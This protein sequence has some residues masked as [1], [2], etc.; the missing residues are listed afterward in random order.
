MKIIKKTAAALTAAV[1]LAAQAAYA[2]EIDV[3]IDSF[4]VTASLRSDTGTERPT[5]QLL[6]SAKSTVLYMG[7]GTSTQNDDDTYTFSFEPFNVPSSLETGQYVIRI[8]GNG[9]AI[10]EQTISFV[11]VNDKGEALNAINSAS[12][13]VAAIIENKDR[14]GI[15][16]LSLEALSDEWKGTISTAVA[17]ADLSNDCSE[18]QVAEKSA[19]FLEAYMPALE[20][21]V[22][23]GSDS[24]DEVNAM[25]EAS[26]YLGL[27]RDG[28]Y[29]KLSDKSSVGGV[30]AEK[31]F[32]TDI[33][34]EELNDE[35]DGAVLVCVINQLDH[36]SAREAL[37]E[38][39]SAG[40]LDVDMSDFDGLSET[41]KANVFKELKKRG[42]TD[43]EDIPGEFEDIVDSYKGSGG[44]STGGGNYGGGGGGGTGGGSTV[45]I[46][47]SPNLPAS[48]PAP[49]S[50][51][52][53]QG[54][55]DMEGFEWAE[56]AVN[57]LSG[58]GVLNGD[59]SGRF[60]PQ[61]YITREEF[62]KI[63]VTAF[64][65]YD[66]SAEAEFDDVPQEAWF[67]SYVASAKNNGIVTGISENEFGAGQNIT[68][69]DMAVML[70]RI[71][72]MAKYDGIT[73]NTDFSDYSE[74][75]DYAQEAVSILSGAGILNGM[76]GG[77]FAPNER[78]TRAQGAKAVYELLKLIEQ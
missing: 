29:S 26:E 45:T 55:T 19:I 52:E 4:T 10:E 1:M 41:N 70:K 42:I 32:G 17:A 57:E 14:L 34:A 43:Y 12:D 44:G 21:A 49:T 76:D 31:E 30:L 13:K 23:A 7:E 36:G 3:K 2:Y 47:G 6:D 61:N 46:P 8:G 37:E 66:S 77:R 60:N 71:F 53:P 63:T 38:Y 72:D 78:V 75:A 65:L 5:I 15:D 54:F 74:I 50:T 22:I 33:T 51:P 67:Y 18:E 39:T 73:P 56:E 68:R 9:T 59:G 28:W 16:T 11:N 24:A 58:R 40:L 35:F 64:D 69:Q 20:K 48:T 25:I 62:A 27:D